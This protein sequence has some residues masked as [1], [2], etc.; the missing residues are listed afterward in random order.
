MGKSNERGEI[1]S[2][3]FNV[4]AWGNLSKIVFPLFFFA[5]CRFAVALL[6]QKYKKKR[7]T[8]QNKSKN[9]K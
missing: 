6:S 2:A 1:P 4:F 9:N 7:K 5:L 8:Q 3:K